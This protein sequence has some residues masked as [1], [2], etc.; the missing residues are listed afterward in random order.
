MTKILIWLLDYV[1]RID[2]KNRAQ[3][4]LRKIHD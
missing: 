2:S 3:Y 4:E 1:L